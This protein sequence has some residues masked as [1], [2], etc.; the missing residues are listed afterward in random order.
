MTS[1]IPSDVPVPRR[2]PR[3]A[4]MGEFSAGKSTLSNLMIGRPAIPTKVT[5][6][7]L[8]PVWISHGTEAPWR[9]DLAGNRHPVDP[10]RMEAVP[11]DD[12][13]FIHFQTEA[14]VL[15]VCDLIDTPGISDPNMPPEVWQRAADVADGVLWLTH[16]TQAWRQ[17]E[18][19]TWEALPEDLH[20]KSL[21]LLTRIDKLTS[22][23]DRDRVIARVTQETQGLFRAVLPVSLTEALAAGEDGARWHASGGEALSEALFELIDDIARHIRMAGDAPRPAAAPVWSPAAPSAPRV[24]RIEPAT[25]PASR[26][27][28]ALRVVAGGSDGPGA[29]VPLP[30]RVAQ[31][32]D[33]GARPA[34]PVE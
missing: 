3:L 13:A 17:S 34:R 7:Q 21:L 30:R 28:P 32:R 4:L 26:Q 2:K 24:T 23:R 25:G 29:G 10:E 27:P 15:Q 12:T 8:P 11:L 19:A 5:A 9:E 16:A 1:D 31:V 20:P 18:A 14:E 22:E 33:R 6:T